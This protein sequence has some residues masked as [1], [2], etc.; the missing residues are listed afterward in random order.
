MDCRRKCLLG[1]KPQRLD[2]QLG[3]I[4]LVFLDIMLKIKINA[5]FVNTCYW[6]GYGALPWLHLCPHLACAVFPL[7]TKAPETPCGQFQDKRRRKS[8]LQER[9]LFQQH[10]P[11]SSDN[12]LICR[13]ECSSAYLDIPVCV[14]ALLFIY[15][16]SNL[17]FSGLLGMVCKLLTW[18]AGS[19]W[20][21][22][23]VTLGKEELN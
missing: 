8:P 7:Q 23:V 15:F 10:C 11:T 9:F 3:K 5:I 18:R 16:S 12:F 21:S 6:G 17:G 19:V 13:W 1:K 14:L 20:C 22:G 2:C 4:L